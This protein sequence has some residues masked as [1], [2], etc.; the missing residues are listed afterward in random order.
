MM[1]YTYNATAAGTGTHTLRHVTGK[2]KFH[3]LDQFVTDANAALTDTAFTRSLALARPYQPENIDTAIDFTL[4]TT[5]NPDTLTCSV[6]Y[7]VDAHVGVYFK[8]KDSNKE[9]IVQVDSITSATVAE[10]TL[11]AGTVG[12]LED[13]ATTLWR[14]DAWN[15]LVYGGTETAPG[16]IWFSKTEDIT[17]F[18][19]NKLKDDVSSESTGLNYFG[20]VLA[21]DAKQYGFTD[22][23]DRR[24]AFINEGRA[25][26]VNK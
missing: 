15:E 24:I 25:L 17:V 3:T 9:V 5:P 23:V 2:W 10:V 11:I 13:T 14:E 1:K 18:M 20:A 26:E 7:F 21:T 8:L 22:T 6:D 16:K 19:V 12:T 4:D